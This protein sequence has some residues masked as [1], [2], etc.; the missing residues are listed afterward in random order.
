MN[1]IIVIEEKKGL[2]NEIIFCLYYFG[3]VLLK[4]LLYIFQSY[5]T[6]ILFAYVLMLMINSFLH[7]KYNEI[8]FSNYMFFIFISIVMLLDIGIRPNEYAMINFYNFVIFGAIALFFFSKVNDAKSLLKNYAYISSFVFVLFCWTPFYDYIFF[9]DYMSF[10]LDV[11]LPSYFGLYIGRKFFNIKWM[12]ILEIA[13]LAEAILFS[14]RSVLLSILFFWIVIGLTYNTKKSLMRLIIVPIVFYFSTYFL[15][16][17]ILFLD[18][19]LRSIGIASYSLKK[20]GLMLNNANIETIFSGRLDIWHQAK[21]MAKQNIFIGNG[22][23]SFQH[24]YGNYTHNVFYDILVQYGLIGVIIMLFLIFNS[25]LKIFKFNYYGKLLGILMLCSWF[26]T[27]FFSTN[28]FI[29]SGIW[30]F[31]ILG[32]K[33]VNTNKSLY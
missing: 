30:C 24:S 17:I 21:N 12:Y 29:N 33:K 25:S 20:F 8:K 23:G 22:T 3:F 6:V 16:D 27:L 15:D 1:D 19:I 13:C 5:S 14:N 7:F 11:I 26:P 4:P 2:T 31:I 18:K 10:G 28:L 9:S 32:F